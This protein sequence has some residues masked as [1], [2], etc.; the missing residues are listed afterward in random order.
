TISSKNSVGPVCI[1]NGAEYSVN[2]K[3][4]VKF[5]ASRARTAN[6]ASSA[7]ATSIL[8]LATASNYGSKTT[9]ATT[10][11]LTISPSTT[12][13]SELSSRTDDGATRTSDA[14]TSSAD[15]SSGE[16]V[17]RSTKDVTVTIPPPTAS[18]EANAPVSSA[19]AARGSVMANGVV[20]SLVVAFL[21]E[22]CL[23]VLFDVD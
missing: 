16:T 12:A 9:V 6:A 8:S 5:E 10:P 2:D 1:F 20:G 21:V 17:L 22:I 14:S 18:T 11:T 4:E 19:S 3:D 23:L 7:T 15:F 13:S